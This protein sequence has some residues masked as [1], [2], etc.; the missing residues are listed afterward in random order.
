MAFDRD[1]KQ[2]DYLRLPHSVDNSAY[3]WVPIPVVSIGNGAGKTA[4]LIAGNHGDEYE[5]QIALLKL[6][7]ELEPDAVRG[8]VIILPALNFPAVDAGRR[9]SPLDEGNLN[10]LF[11]G[12]AHGSPTS[13]IAHYVSSV[14]FPLA[15]IVI[16]L[17]SGGRSLEYFPVALARPGLNAGDEARIRT[18]LEVFAA[19]VSIVTDGA[20]GGGATTLYAAA[21]AVGI[22]AI[23]AE[24]GGGAT[25]SPRGLSIAYEGVRRVLRHYGIAPEL[26]VQPGEPSR[27]MRS[28]G[29]HASVYADDASLFEPLARP[30]ETVEAG[31]PAGILHFYDTPLREPR[32]LHFPAGGVVS[33]MRHPT[34]TRRGDCLYHLVEDIP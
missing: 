10:R 13:M 2:A 17:H 12:D 6:A 22:P 20:G 7:R 26:A 9:V 28:L 24:L 19:P 18:L 23:T 27:F 31:Q 32:V 8:R 30:G 25:L 4:L 3:G 5:G 1:G 11:P 16:D 21:E 14:L 29:T 15:D 34:I 33:C